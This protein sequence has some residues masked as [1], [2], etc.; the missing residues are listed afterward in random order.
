MSTTAAWATWAARG[1]SGAELPGLRPLSPEA[2]RLFARLEADNIPIMFHQGTS[3]FIYA[4]L[5]YAHPLT[6]DKVGMAFPNLT[7][8]LAHLAHPWIANVLRWFASTQTFGLTFLRSFTG[9]I[10]SGRGCSFLRM[11]RDGENSF[12]SDW[13]VT[14]PQDNIDHLRG[15]SKYAKD[16]YLPSVPENEIEG[17]INRDAVEILGID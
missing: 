5:A 17:I 11:G 14:T 12:G 2:F 16:H 13:P 15:L 4:P 9:L 10:R 7:M 6:T 8:V 1:S 3:P